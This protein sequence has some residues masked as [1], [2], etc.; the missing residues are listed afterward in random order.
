M[1]FFMH[2]TACFAA[3]CAVGESTLLPDEITAPAATCRSRDDADS[4]ALLQMHQEL[5]SIGAGK[6]VSLLHLQKHPHHVKHQHNAKH[7]FHNKAHMNHHAKVMP[8]GL[9]GTTADWGQ[10]WALAQFAPLNPRQTDEGP[11]ERLG[12]CSASLAQVMYYHRRCPTGKVEF[13][14]PGYPTTAMDFDEEAQHG[15]CDWPKFV[16]HS[17]NFTEDPGTSAVA[18]YIYAMSLTVRRKW[19]SY[20]D[21]MKHYLI[22]HEEQDAVVS[23][24]Y[25]MN[26]RRFHIA[27]TKSSKIMAEALL[28]KEIN[29]GR[30]V[31]AFLVRHGSHGKYGHMVVMDGFRKVGSASKVR[32][33]A[34]YNGHNNGWFHFRGPFCFHRYTNGTR[35]LNGTCARLYDHVGYLKFVRPKAV[36]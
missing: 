21:D 36:S 1:M 24:H 35:P 34:G 32:I 2:A 14:I 30:P 29:H 17:L 31:I 4:V 26:I 11:N 15:L 22:D 9:L 13:T 3:I 12:C 8:Q 23:A 33:N 5:A 28:A 18:K 27:R 7:P 6:N 16:G 10:R 25:G 20:A 19:G